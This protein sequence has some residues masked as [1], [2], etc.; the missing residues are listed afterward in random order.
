MN[1]NILFKLGISVLT[2]SLIFLVPSISLAVSNLS[3]EKINLVSKANDIL[4]DNKSRSLQNTENNKVQISKERMDAM[5][6]IARQ[7][8]TLFLSSVITNKEKS[9]LSK[10]VQSNIENEV[11]ID[12]TLS[13]IVSDDF[14]NKTEKIQY[15]IISGQNTYNYYPA[16]N[17]KNVKSGDN[18]SVKG[19]TL[20]NTLVSKASDLKIKRGAKLAS[21]GSLDSVGNQRMAVFLLKNNASTPTNLSVEQVKKIVFNDKFSR[22]MTE[23]SNG[24]ISFTGD[25]FDWSISSDPNFSIFD[26]N[27]NCH[28]PND[29]SDLVSKYKINISNYDRVVFLYT[30]DGYGGGCSEVGKT[31]RTIN[32]ITNKLSLTVVS[33]D[34]YIFYPETDEY[35][36]LLNDF[37]VVLSHEFGH[38]LGLQHANGLQCEN[39]I[40][41]N[42]CTDLEYGNHFDTMGFAY[43][44]YHFNAYYKYLLGWL[45]PDQ[46]INVDKSGTYEISPQENGSKAR[47]VKI[48]YSNKDHYFVEMRAPFGFDTKLKNDEFVSNIS[49]IFINKISNELDQLKTQL[50]D[51]SP[52]NS[53]NSNNNFDDKVTLNNPNLNTSLKQFTDQNLGIT[54]GPI[55]SVNINNTNSTLSSI[56]FNVTLNN[57]DCV[58]KLPDVVV[59]EFHSDGTYDS[60]TWFGGDVTIKN[61]DSSLCNSSDYTLKFTD[62]PIGWTQKIYPSQMTLG[63]GDADSFIYQLKIPSDAI[64]NNYTVKMELK[65]IKTGWVKLIEKTIYV[66]GISNEITAMP[67]TAPSTVKMSSTFY[68]TLN[69]TGGP[70]PITKSIQLNFYDKDNVLKFSEV[71]NP[72]K[73]TTQ[74]SNV[75]S[76]PAFIELPG[77]V[78]PGSYKVGLSLFTTAELRRTL[79]SNP[80]EKIIGSVEVIPESAKNV[81]Y[82]NINNIDSTAK[83]NSEYDIPVRTSE[84]K[85]SISILPWYGPSSATV[86]STLHY[87][88]T[89]R[90]GPTTQ[91]QRI[92]VHFIDQ[93]GNIKFVSDIL[94]ST[95]TTQWSGLVRIPVTVTVPNGITLGSY[96]V[97]AGLYSGSSS[98]TLNPAPGVLQYGNNTN[99]YQVGTVSVLRSGSSPGLASTASVADSV[100][101]VE[102][103][104]K[105]ETKNTN[106]ASVITTSSQISSTPIYNSSGSRNGRTSSVPTPVP[107]PTSSP[108]PTPTATP[109]ASPSPVSSPVIE[110]HGSSPTT[111]ASPVTSV[112]SA[113]VAPAPA[114]AP[115]SE[116]APAPV[117]SAPVPVSAPSPA[118]S[119]TPAPSPSVSEEK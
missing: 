28:I 89:F 19:Y 72:S 10:S 58:A 81:E 87:I 53:S 48:N 21:T 42:N 61:L 22:F 109:S 104:K 77:D 16:G 56:K 88:I 27:G 66:N 62:A 92:F 51:M 105:V 69:F 114:P 106:Y 113:P 74:W 82:K 110:S 117:V 9:L 29:L 94:P 5:L 111:T 95:P 55:T 6:S 13:I 46:I 67:W 24:K 33:L 83:Y 101:A 98:V 103:N 65:N 41:G 100:S 11:N 70:S 25:V 84:S 7:N 119:A 4:L 73:P 118:P 116:P 49:G 99:R 36:N 75:T 31:S 20:S 34:D 1:R 71:V 79:T 76:I 108:T 68:A 8:P 64:S 52:G 39:N 85:Q 96:K 18:V 50:L 63:S 35:K 97:V 47:L 3:Y 43:N 93:V 90:G 54:I 59:G 23:Q 40:V 112:P 44:S 107:S 86:D 57:P 17:L 2:L 45:N 14:K 32:G 26:E 115:V 60:G 37:E 80:Y 38:A 12:G 102:S 91:S 78:P 15:K 30:A